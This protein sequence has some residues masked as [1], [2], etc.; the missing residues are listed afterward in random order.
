MFKSWPPFFGGPLGNPRTPKMAPSKAVVWSEMKPPKTA[1]ER[2]AYLTACQRE[3][4]RVQVLGP[5]STEVLLPSPR[6]PDASHHHHP[7]PTSFTALS[8]MPTPAHHTVCHVCST[9]THSGVL[10]NPFADWVVLLCPACARSCTG[11]TRAS[12]ADASG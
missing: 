12:G 3:F 10:A 7:H 9:G 1:A 4:E 2:T 5:V 8:A 6:R 11:V